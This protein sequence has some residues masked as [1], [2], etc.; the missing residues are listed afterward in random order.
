MTDVP[1]AEVRT[2]RFPLI[3]LVP[4]AAVGIAVW[5]GVRT[6]GDHGPL[7]KIT[8][9]SG[10]GLE[11]GRTRVMLR[12]VELGM[13]ESMEL[14]K[15]LTHVVVHA[16][17]RGDLRPYLTTGTKFWVVRPRLGAGG[18]S[19]LNTLFSGAYL[20]ISPGKG[21]RTEQFEGLDEP[22]VQAPSGEGKTFLLRASSLGGL[23]RGS[24][25]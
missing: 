18:V 8:L 20:E 24:P 6:L 11:A 13:V 23:S 21:D 1:Q 14:S 17:I 16:R 3:W 19:G 4:L 7:V 12:N 10:E 2:R 9:S 22:P 25:V 15:D 5:L